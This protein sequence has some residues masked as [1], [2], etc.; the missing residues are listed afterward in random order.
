MTWTDTAFMER[1]LSDTELVAMIAT[2]YS[3]PAIFPYLWIPPLDKDPNVPTLL[4]KPYIITEGDVSYVPQNY[5]GTICAEGLRDIRI[6]GNKLLGAEQVT[7]VADRV[8]TLFRSDKLQSG[9]V[10]FPNALIN[11][12][13]CTALGPMAAPTEGTFIGKRIRVHFRVEELN[14]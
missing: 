4:R 2:A 5:K 14:S 7:A 8:A 10:M 3:A 6:Y 9:E 1:M 11:L 13:D 12:I